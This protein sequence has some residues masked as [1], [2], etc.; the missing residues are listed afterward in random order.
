MKEFI[1][2]IKFD[3]KGLVPV[4]A[5]EYRTDEILMLAYMNEEAL[6]LSIETGKATYWSRS[7]NEL[8][9]KGATSGNYQEIVSFAVDCDGDTL[10]IKVKQTGNACH[11]GQYSCFFRKFDN[12]KLA[13]SDVE[14]AKQIEKSA[15]SAITD[16]EL[17]NVLR[18]LFDV[19]SDRKVNPK[20]GSYT[21][22]LFSKGLD[23]ILKKIGEETA[24]VIIASKNLSNDE[25]KYEVSDLL[26]HLF[27][28]LVERGIDLNEIFAELDRRK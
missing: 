8:W 4:I 18:G 15:E 3:E 5:Q 12:E 9:I 6:K 17:N 13:G 10:I 14:E 25:I 28:L 11:T 2:S 24:E 23:K 22:Y 26:Y 1:D 21:N 27:V 7:R 19:I 20:D 16:E